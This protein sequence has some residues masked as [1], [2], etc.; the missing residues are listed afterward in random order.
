MLRKEAS[1]PIFQ[2][3]GV[4][5]PEIEPQSPGPFVNTLLTFP[6]GQLPIYIYIY[7]YV[8]VCVCDQNAL[9]L[10]VYIFNF[11]TEHLKLKWKPG[12]RWAAKYHK[13]MMSRCLDF[14][15][16]IKTKSKYS[17]DMFIM[18]CFWG[19]F[20]LCEC[21]TLHIHQ[22]QVFMLAAPGFSAKQSGILARLM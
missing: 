7:I 12:H 17:L 4:I 2:V 8:C 5:R 1:N 16:G 11:K 21:S 3:F 22:Y 6:I 13:L 19:N 9:R 14:C 18:K 10:K 20:G 15:S